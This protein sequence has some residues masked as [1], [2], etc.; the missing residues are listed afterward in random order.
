MP[1]RPRILFL[2]TANACRSQMAEAIARHVGGT[3]LE[4]FSAGSRPAGFIHELAMEAMRRL[5]ISLEGQRS[6]GWDEYAS[7]SFDA[8]ITLCDAAAH[9]GCPVFPGQ[10]MTVHWS[11]PDPAYFPGSDDQRIEFTLRVA[12]SL[13]RKIEGLAALDWSS[14]QDDLQQRIQFLAEV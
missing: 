1:P 14:P 5:G 10:P 6:K 11:I 7:S 9:E 2:C 12:E 4:A 3:R 13:R 8:V